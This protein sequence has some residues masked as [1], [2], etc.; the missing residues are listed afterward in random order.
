IKKHWIVMLIIILAPLI[1]VGI[2]L[3]G[4]WFHWTWT[5]FGPE[6]SEPKQHAKTLWDWLQLLIVPI[7]LALGATLF[8]RAITQNEQKVAEQR[9]VNEQKII[10]QRYLNDQHI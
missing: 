10:E 7:V 2:M 3:G 4:Y 5:G 9:Y 1:L 6:T 8:N